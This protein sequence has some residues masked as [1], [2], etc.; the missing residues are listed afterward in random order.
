MNDFHHL[1]TSGRT[2]EALERL[3]THIQTKAPAWQQS[4]VLLRASWAQLEKETLEGVISSEEAELRRNRIQA[5]A[6]Q[7]AEQMEQ[8]NARPDD[9][10]QELKGELWNEDIAE[11]VNAHNY[12]DLDDAKIEIEDSSEVI[13]GSGNTVNRNIFKALGRWQFWGLL[14]I[15]VIIGA[16]LVFGSQQLL[17]QQEATFNSLEEIRQELNRLADEGGERW[18]EQLPELENQ[19]AVGM[20][21]L[22]KGD[23]QTATQQLEAVAKVAPLATVYQNLAYAYEQE[24]KIEEAYQ[25]RQ[26]ARQID[27]DIFAPK[28]AE[29]IKGRYVNL[30]APEHGR[31]VLAVT[32]R[33]LEALVDGE[34]TRTGN[35][36]PD[37]WI[38]FAFNQE[39]P[40]VIDRLDY[41]VPASN[42]Y[43][44]SALEIW[45][46]TQSADGPFDSVGLFSV[47]NV[48][49]TRQPFQE[50]SWKPIQAKYVKI[51]LG[52]PFAGENYP[53]R[54]YEM[55][56][57]GQLR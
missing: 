54:G 45:T 19:L 33:T 4:I 29:T 48:H 51:K 49:L 37:G 38:V 7:L 16:Y 23:Y 31:E 12:T 22:Q 14:L 55:R 42:R 8:P 26:K 20:K 28:P 9:L 47:Q 32:D 10:W 21:A 30:L 27:S 17:G 3:Q 35:L 57:W 13:I 52:N 56:L 39:R 5:G 25:M 15:L 44:L 11:S 46:S 43:T 40:A 53:S 1:I 41:Y 36:M 34:L 18:Q 6:L 24:G 2:E 50:F